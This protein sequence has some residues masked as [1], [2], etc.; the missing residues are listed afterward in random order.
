MRMNLCKFDPLRDGANLC[1]H[2]V[3][4]AL[5]SAD[6]AVC[7]LVTSD[8]F[9]IWIPVQSSV[10][11]NCNIRQV[12]RGQRA[13]VSEDIRDGQTTVACAFNEVLHVTAQ[14]LAATEFGQS[15]FGKRIRFQFFDWLTA[16]DE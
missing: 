15:I 16:E 9:L 13:M 7:E 10:Q 14:L 3:A 1:I 8:L 4:L 12:A 5:R 11:S 6:E 2:F